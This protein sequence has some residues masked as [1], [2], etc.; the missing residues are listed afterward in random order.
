M[1]AKARSIAIVAAPLA[2]VGPVVAAAVTDEWR[3]LGAGF[4]VGAGALMAGTGAALVQSSLVPIAMPETDNPFASGESG[5]GIVAASLLA[6]VLTGLAAL[7]VPVALALLWATDRGDP[8]LVTVFASVTV[9]VGWAA[10][11]IGIAIAVRRIGGRQPEFVAAIT[12][13]R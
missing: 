13:A 7:T 6:V 1:V 12:P 10:L 3:Y 4:G 5:K 8:L 9:L 11:R 2:V